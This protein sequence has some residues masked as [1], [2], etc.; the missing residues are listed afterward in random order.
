[1]LC[2][3]VRKVEV[4]EEERGAFGYVRREAPLNKLIISSSW[5]LLG[6]F[7]NRVLAKP[8]LNFSWER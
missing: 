8:V 1:M 2:C 5:E 4:F 3:G 6:G 7:I